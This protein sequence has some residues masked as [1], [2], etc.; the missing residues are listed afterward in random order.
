V[1]I[2]R[3]VELG[4]TSLSVANHNTVILLQ[5]LLGA[6]C[7]G[8]DCSQ[9]QKLVVRYLVMIRRYLGGKRSLC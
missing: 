7:C 4:S 8:E 5:Q 2:P 1:I 3:V 9:L 6:F